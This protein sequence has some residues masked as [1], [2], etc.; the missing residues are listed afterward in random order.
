LRRGYNYN[1]ETDQ[2]NTN[3]PQHKHRIVVQHGTPA[4]M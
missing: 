3:S 1:Q 2:E 4:S